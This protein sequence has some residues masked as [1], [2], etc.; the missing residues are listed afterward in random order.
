MFGVSCAP[1]M[2][3]RVSQLLLED[4]DGVRNI[5]DD[6]IL[7]GQTTE[8]HDKQL[9]QA[10]E[11]IQNRGL[12][13]NKEKCKFHMSELEFMGDLLSARGIGPSHTKVEAVTEARQ[14]E[15]AAQVHSFLGLVNFY[16]RFIPDLATV[17][18]H[19]RGLKRKDVPF[20][21][22]KEQEA[23]F[24]ELKRGWPKQKLWV[25]LTVLQ[26]TLIITDASPVGLGA[27]IVQEQDGEEQ[28]IW[29]A[30]WSLTDV[31]IV[32]HT[33]RK[34]LLG[35]CGHV[36]GY[37]CI[38]MELILNS[39]QITTPAVYLLQEVATQCKGQSLGVETYCQTHTWER[40]HCRF[41]LSSYKEQ[42]K[43]RP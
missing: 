13:L 24:N 41:P 4:C 34:R 25:T 40:K 5:H 39:Q 8:D 9:E 37:T 10:M 35:S 38:C 20:S 36:K 7:H 32:I 23:A 33:P 27:I 11:G 21:W 26:K 3:Q 42:S 1:E 30:S 12:T 6:I 29:Y 31:E 18:E 15:P 22:G 19:L 28:V 16:A 17:S 14:P 43:C 2:Y